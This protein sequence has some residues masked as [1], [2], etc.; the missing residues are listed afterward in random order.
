MRRSTITRRNVLKT[1]AL[2]SAAVAQP[3]IDVG[4]S[5]TGAFSSAAQAAGLISAGQSFDPYASDENFLLGAFIF[6]AVGVTD[7]VGVWQH[8]SQLMTVV[9]LKQRY[10]GHAKRA[11][12][13]AA[14]NSYMARLIVIVDDDVD[15]I[16][17][18]VILVLAFDPERAARPQDAQRLNHAA[19]IKA[20]DFG[21]AHVIGHRAAIAD[22]LR[23]RLVGYDNWNSAHDQR[24]KNLLQHLDGVAGG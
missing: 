10:A 18:A 5:A 9:A 20:H 16:L 3:T 6:E 19:A 15:P 2:G 4:T 17:P 7:V 11:G 24:M 12:L 1:A 14:A 23:G 22:Q 21:V 13:I 8:V